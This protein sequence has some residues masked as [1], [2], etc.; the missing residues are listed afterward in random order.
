VLLVAAACALANGLDGGV[1][2][3]AVPPPGFFGV[4]G[5]T[6]PS[7]RQSASLGA[8]GL[9]LVRAA[10]GLANVQPKASPSSRDWTSLDRLMT[11]AA[12]DDFNLILDLNGCARWACGK[13]VAAPSSGRALSDYETFVAAAVARYEPSSPFWQ[14]KPRIPT[15]TWQVWNEVNA[16]YFWPHPTPA[17]YASFLASIDQTIHSVDPSAAVIMSGLTGL[18]AGRGGE[19]VTRFLTGL[20]AQPGFASHTD[21]IVVHGY[22]RDPAGAYAVLDE[23]RRVML[24][25]GDSAQPLWVTEMSWASGGPASPFTVSA[26]KQS[27]W[28]TQSW[29]T[30]LGCAPRWNLQHVLW[31]ALQDEN[32]RRFGTRDYYGFH[33]GL[34]SVGGSPKPSYASFLR[35]VGSQPLPDGGGDSCP[36]PGGETIDLATPQLTIESYAKATNDR[37]S[38]PISFAASENGEPI[39]GM[40]YECSLDGARYRPCTSPFNAASSREG[41]HTLEVRAIDPQGNRS[42]PIKISWL[43]DLTPPDT[44]ITAHSVHGNQATVSFRGIDAGGIGGFQCK[45]DKAAWQECSSPY[46]TS[47]LARG[48]HALRVRAVDRAGNRDRSPAVLRFRIG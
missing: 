24:E 7:A 26:A 44:R 22:A 38:Q 45:L 20:L 14:G 6:Y 32:H 16:G 1:A 35:F 28:L 31:F 30:M 34:L 21:A 36:L 27:A 13:V 11:Q 19:G 5:W 47:V 42:P 25:H 12:D 46:T 37:R 40:R 23:A 48:R 29:D 4:G 17:A 39:A 33:N 10:V 8:A 2:A 41:E 3:A 43:V 18:P 15:I 9:R